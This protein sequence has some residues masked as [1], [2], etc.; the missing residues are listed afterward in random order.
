VFRQTLA[1]MKRLHQETQRRVVP[2]ALEVSVRLVDRVPAIRGTR[3]RNSQARRSTC[4]RNQGKSRG[5]EDKWSGVQD[6]AEAPSVFSQTTRQVWRSTGAQMKPLG[7]PRWPLSKR[8]PNPPLSYRLVPLLSR[9][10]D[11]FSIKRL[12]SIALRRLPQNQG[13][14]SLASSIQESGDKW[15]DLS[16]RAGTKGRALSPE[17]RGN[18]DAIKL[19]VF[20]DGVVHPGEVGCGTARDWQGNHL[21]MLASHPPVPSLSAWFYHAGS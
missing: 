13:V 7:R 2:S 3:R 11:V 12:F 8:A 9:Y 4:S 19:V 17:K 5:P 1:R 6:V 16:C 14:H 20:Y 15:M 21:K 18:L 10:S